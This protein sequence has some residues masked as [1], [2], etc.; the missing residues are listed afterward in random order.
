[1]NIFTSQQKGRMNVVLNN[2]PRRPHSTAVPTVCHPFELA[3]IEYHP[4]TVRSCGPMTISF[5]NM[6]ELTPQSS[7]W[8]FSGLTASPSTST[9]SAVSLTVF[10]TGMLNA[11]LEATYGSIIE[12]KSVQ[13]SVIILAANQAVCQTPSCFDGVRNGNE[14]GMDCGGSCGA[15]DPNCDKAIILNGPYT[16]S[17]NQKAADLIETGNLTGAG[18]VFINSGETITLQAKQILLQS[19]FNV[20]PNAGLEVKIGGCN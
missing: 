17:Q 7:K 4:K 6:P 13:M 18:Q 10:S 5:S 19:G 15:C 8:T 1:M 11:Q 20:N 14:T 16:I 3:N 12:E 9:Q 2:S